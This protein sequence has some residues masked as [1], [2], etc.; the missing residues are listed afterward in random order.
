MVTRH[1]GVGPAQ[2]RPAGEL[3]DLL[4][5]LSTG[6]HATSRLDFTAGTAMPDGRL[7]LCKQ[8]LG[9]GG[10]AAV[11]AT[12]R[13]G[14]VK[15]LLLGT[16]GLGSTGATAIA[17]STGDARI[18]TL[19]LGCNG[20]TSAGA[21]SF[22]ERLRASPQMLTGLWLKR[23]PIGREGAIA[24]VDY[25]AESPRMR[26]LDLTQT[27]LDGETVRR[28]AETLLYATAGGHRLQR[29][30]LGG[31]QLF[32]S[33]AD[34]VAGL[35]ASG[36]VDELYV[37]AAWLGNAGAN[38][39]A[40]A[41][42]VAPYGRLRRLSLA[43]NGFGPEL[44]AEIC[45]QAI[46]AGIEVLDLGRVKSAGV[47]GAENNRVDESAA[48]RIG[49]ALAAGSHRMHH[50]I[51]ADTG[52]GSRGALHLL[53]HTEHATTPTRFLLGKGIAASVKKR[54]NALSGGLPALPELPPD[55]AAIRSVHRTAHMP[56]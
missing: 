4:H 46:A 41:L 18:E 49:Q 54:L 28:I 8:A 34:A 3:A 55:V 38:A 42:R 13:P 45:V 9:P 25:T 16:N 21:C 1:A 56:R 43:S 53:A 7:D 10:A 20:I 2:P 14:V 17:A 12:L 32:D 35:I 36:A 44:A 26:T 27:G 24:A 19:Y 33:G 23:N 15:H 51:L 48:D 52:L 22:T 5:W 39:I 37:P 30:Y 31:N 11:T 47:L 40:D 6:E 29:L 50:L